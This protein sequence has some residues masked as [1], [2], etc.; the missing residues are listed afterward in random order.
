M[1]HE[2]SRRTM[3]ASLSDGRAKYGPHYRCKK[4]VRKKQIEGENFLNGIVAIDETWIRSYEPELKRQSSEWHTPESPRPVKYLRAWAYFK[5]MMIF[6]YDNSGILCACG[7]S[8]GQTVNQE[9]Y[10]QFLMH[11]L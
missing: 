2:T 8:S 11:S 7:V 4:V 9:C 10:R 6:A 5:M 3:G 1:E